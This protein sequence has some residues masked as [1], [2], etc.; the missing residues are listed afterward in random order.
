MQRF[1]FFFLWMV[2]VVLFGLTYFLVSVLVS[3]FHLMNLT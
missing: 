3:L 2:A 1:L